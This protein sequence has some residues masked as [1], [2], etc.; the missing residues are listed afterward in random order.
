M[1]VPEDFGRQPETEPR[2][3]PPSPDSVRLLSPLGALNDLP[4][5]PHLH[6]AAVYQVRL[7]RFASH[8]V[9]RMKAV[10][11]KYWGLN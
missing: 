11:S 6:S 3:S 4:R 8:V 2:P 10:S 7:S 1:C 9:C 5:R